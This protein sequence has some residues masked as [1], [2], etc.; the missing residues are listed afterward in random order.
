MNKLNF[1][2]IPE[3]TPLQLLPVLQKI[4]DT[5][6]LWYDCYQTIP[7]IHRHS[8]GQK[9]DNLF[10]QIIEAITTASFLS[11][12]KKLP[13]VCTAIQ[14]VDTLKIFLMIIWETKSLDNKKYIALSIKIDEIGR[15]LG[16]WN[17]Q[18]QKQNSPTK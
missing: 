4:K 1:P 7:K 12:D 13:Y 8:L 17:G 10:V 6:L 3:Y 11:R 2:H 18:L 5:Y 9:V 15:M 14:K 16:G